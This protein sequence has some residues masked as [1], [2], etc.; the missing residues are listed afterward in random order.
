MSL[1]LFS[2][3]KKKTVDFN[4]KPP[5]DIRDK[6]AGL[7]LPVYMGS[8][9]LYNRYQLVGQQKIS[10]GKQTTRYDSIPDYFFQFDNDN[11]FISYGY[12]YRD[13][14]NVVL[15]GGGNLLFTDRYLDSAHG[16]AYTLNRGNGVDFSLY[17]GADT[18]QT[19]F[20][21]V[22]CIKTGGTSGNYRWF[23]HFGF[24]IGVVREEEY[25]V[26]NK[27]DTTQHYLLELESYKINK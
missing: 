2:C 14:I 15:S 21:S 10:L 13:G 25:E 27:N 16:R 4:V 26:N 19:K 18:L 11:K 8:H 24:G 1:L 23:R 22:R 17:G 3:M 6:G 7:Y 9:W 20:G 5:E 12:W